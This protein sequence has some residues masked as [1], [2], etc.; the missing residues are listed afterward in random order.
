MSLSRSPRPGTKSACA[1][2]I[3]EGV[4]RANSNRKLLV[5]SHSL[6][7]HAKFVHITNGIALSIPPG[8][9]RSKLLFTAIILWVR[10]AQLDGCMKCRCAIQK[11]RALMLLL[12]MLCD[13]TTWMKTIQV[14]LAEARYLSSKVSNLALK[15]TATRSIA[16]GRVVRTSQYEKMLVGE[17]YGC[18]ALSGGL[19]PDSWFALSTQ[20]DVMDTPFRR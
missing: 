20:V 7:R 12:G 11:V 3:K 16:F 19:H 8:V 14:G 18:D 13:Q 6:S 10:E 9:P 5:R 4:S 1:Y 17:G 2:P 15:S